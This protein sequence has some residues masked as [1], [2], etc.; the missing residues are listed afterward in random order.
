MSYKMFYLDRQMD[1][2][3]NRRCVIPLMINISTEVV[4]I[5]LSDTASIVGCVS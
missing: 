5:W 1:R 2:Q 3:T 4:C